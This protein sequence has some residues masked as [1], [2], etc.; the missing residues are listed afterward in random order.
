MVLCVTMVKEHY[1]EFF[2]D[3]KDYNKVKASIYEI[4]EFLHDVVEFRKTNI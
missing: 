3:D 2:H 1:A 4:C